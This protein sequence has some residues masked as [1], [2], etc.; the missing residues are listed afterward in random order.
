MRMTRLPGIHHDANCVVV[1]GRASV[2]LIDAGTSWYQA[3]QVERILGLLGES[4]QPEHL[5]LTSR[6][7]PF[8][9]PRHTSPNVGRGCVCM[10]RSRCERLGYG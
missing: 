1:Q 4:V 7:Y 9:G 8:S 10:W 6:R 2:V 5:L 3:L